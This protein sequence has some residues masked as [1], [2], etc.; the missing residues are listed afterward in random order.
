MVC[1][2]KKA[3]NLL[4]NSLLSENGQIIMQGKNLFNNSNTSTS[5]LSEWYTSCII[6]LHFPDCSLKSFNAVSATEKC[7]FHKWNISSRIVNLVIFNICAMANYCPVYI[8]HFSS[9]LAL[10]YLILV[11]KVCTI[12]H[13]S[14]SASE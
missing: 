14:L 11:L 5:L 3:Y 6:F 4:E 1:A 13:I 9:L 12:F 8:F 2:S 10:Y 7:E